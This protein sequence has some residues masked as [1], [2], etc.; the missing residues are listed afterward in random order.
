MATDKAL[1]IRR[2][3]AIDAIAAALGRQVKG[4]HKLPA[5]AEIQTL[6][7][8]AQALADGP[9]SNA[10][11]DPDLAAAIKAAGQA[12]L[13]AIPGIGAKTAAALID[14]AEAAE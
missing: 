3:A 1:A 5:Q 14:W 12:G 4:R 11:S 9:T 2:E 13:E 6:E 10:E 8:I 7:N